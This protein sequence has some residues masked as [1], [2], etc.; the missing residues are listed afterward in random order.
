MF[1]PVSL[2]IE[3]STS[4]KEKGVVLSVG[5]VDFRSGSEAYWQITHD[6]YPIQP[7]SMEVNKID[8]QT[9]VGL[10]QSDTEPLIEAYLVKLAAFHDSKYLVPIGLNVAGFDM[11]Y[12]RHHFHYDTLKLLGYRSIDLNA[13]IF[14]E[15]D[16]REETFRD[17][18]RKLRKAGNELTEKFLAGREL[19]QHHALYDAYFNCFVYSLLTD[20]VPSWMGIR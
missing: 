20:N 1:F 16:V 3:T 15:A 17:T 5:M 19:E 10:G 13:L 11:A 14:R 18:K 7:K 4:E 9:W 2:D 12:L 6:I 8:L